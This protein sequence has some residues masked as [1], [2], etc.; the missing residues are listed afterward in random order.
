[1]TRVNIR[2]ISLMLALL[3]VVCVPVLA[4]NF[5]AQITGVVTDSTGAVIPGADVTAT[6]IDT[7]VKQTAQTNAEGI[8]R[9]LNLLP[10]KYRVEAESPGF[11][12]FVQKS[13]TLR[14]GDNVD[15]SIK[16]AVGQVTEEVTV[17]SE[18]PLLESQTA[19]FSQVVDQRAISEL[20][21]NTRTPMALVATTPGVVTGKYFAGGTGDG[22]RNFFSSD[23][24]IG[25]GRGE[26]QEVLIDGA[27]N[28]T[29]DRS[30]VAY[31]PPVD[32]TRE[33]SVQ[34][35]SYSAEFG[36]TT[37]GTL[38]IVTKSGTNQFH[39]VAYDYLRNSALDANE[40]FANRSGKTKGT[41]RRNQFGANFGGPIFKDKTFFFVAYEGT[42]RATPSTA[43]S[44]LPTLKQR[45]G[46]FSETYASN[47]KLIAIYDYSTLHEGPDGELIREP[48]PGNIIP[49]S[50]F[51]PVAVN[52]L[53]YYPEPNQPGKPITG[54]NNFVTRSNGTND[55]DKTDIRIDQNFSASNRIFGRFSY[56]DNTRLNPARWD[57]AANPGSRNINDTYTN[58]TVSDVHTFTPTL[59]GEMRFS[60]ARAHANQ[61][62]PSVGFDLSSLGFP[63]NYV[64]QAAPMFPE[65][66]IGGMTTMGSEFFNNQ[67]RN[68][69]SGIFNIS[70]MSG[71]HSLKFGADIRVLR[72]HALQNNTPTGDFRFYGKFTRGPDPFKSSKNAGFG[73]AD[74][75]LGAGTKGKIDH[76]NGL[77]LQRLYYAF[78]VQDD[79]RITPK[80]TLNL[81]LRYDV[82]TGQ[83]ER[84]DRLASFDPDTRSPLSDEVDMNL[85]GILRYLG[86]NGEPR[87][88]YDT[89]WN[90][91]GPRFGFAYKLRNRTV[92]RG[93]YGIFYAPM[94]TLSVGSIGFNSSTPWVTSIDG[95]TPTN[96]LS[97][98]FPQGFNLPTGETDPLTNVGYSLGIN[99]RGERTPYVQQWNFGLQQEFG[100]NLLLEVAYVGAKGTKLQFGQNLPMNALPTEALT[101]G[102]DLN[103]KVDNPFYGVIE[104]GPLS[105]PKVSL[106]HMLQ[107]MPQYTSVTRSLPDMGSSIYHGLTIKVEKRLSAGLSLLAAYTVSKQI[108]DSSS[109]EGWLDQAPGLLHTHGAYADRHLERSISAYD[110]PQRLVLSHVYDLPFGKDRAIGGNW[111]SVLDAILGGWSWSGILTLQSGLPF[112]VSRPGVNNGQTPKLDNPTI[113]RWFNTSF[114]SPAEPFTFGNVGRLLP[115][116]RSDG[117]NSYDT[118]IAKNFYF[119]ERFRLQFRAEFF[120]A[121]NTP[122]FQAPNGG[123][124]SR[125]FGV[126]SRTTGSPRQI[127]FALKLFW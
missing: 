99:T 37:G 71:K 81:G 65:F 38:N 94:I 2:S 127:Q 96:F 12:R 122:Q 97:D 85:K 78:Y 55:S 8:Y 68:T 32:S 113:D 21:L 53:T 30:F 31:I 80:L 47:G 27:P 24:K 4:Q 90:N 46:D 18:A 61:L 72:F 91:F 41:F 101:L 36:R 108:D 62:V 43:T 50:R 105:G 73:L 52:A 60:F 119:M 44:T 106:G 126:V 9:L 10:G 51:D 49:S 56:Q 88:Q 15:L 83:T 59:V 70:K 86:R 69:Y 87:N 117:I 5:R 25:G 77:S 42:R 115:V 19:T 14:V 6:N 22:G 93:G 48:F 57:N 35:N 45:Q 76:I 7:G 100:G 1:M 116:T 13:V 16:L 112:A 123:I 125:N 64:K 95:L 124:T 29:G 11:R 84:F 79:W 34:T 26:A 114:F 33:F 54:T 74:F 75:L 28:T 102:P 39:G 121:T 17:T 104:K 111:N 20:P 107:P 98:P 23:F 67:P 3:F 82:T 103:K 109:Q 92:V 89:D 40:F 118:S 63:E 58:V 110:V 120:N 66:R